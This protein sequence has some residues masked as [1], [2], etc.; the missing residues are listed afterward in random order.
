MCSSDLVDA[1][2]VEDERRDWSRV[3]RRDPTHLL[4]IR[5]ADAQLRPETAAVVICCS[6]SAGEVRL[7]FSTLNIV[8]PAVDDDGTMPFQCARGKYAVV[9]PTTDQPAYLYA[10]NIQK[11]VKFVQ[12]RGLQPESS[13]MSLAFCN[14]LNSSVRRCLT[15]NF[16]MPSI[17][18]CIR[19]SRIDRTARSS[20]TSG[21]KMSGNVNPGRKGS[22]WGL[23]NSVSIASGSCMSLSSSWPLLALCSWN[24]RLIMEVSA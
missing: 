9:Q 3:V 10:F 11:S 13:K 1:A 14:Y 16:V 12:E 18:I 17:S 2:V 24:R 4:R 21:I 22:D 7:A 23:V 8:V 5:S 15:G 20:V 19:R 6:A